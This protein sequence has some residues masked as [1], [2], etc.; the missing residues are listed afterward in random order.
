LPERIATKP[1]RNKAKNQTAT[2][3]KTP[4]QQ[5]ASNEADDKRR[6][7]TKNL[8][9]RQAAHATT[10]TTHETDTE[11]TVPTTRRIQG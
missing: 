8:Q 5:T 1:T 7:R 11:K 4:S 10:S 2:L 3:P 6:C 9:R